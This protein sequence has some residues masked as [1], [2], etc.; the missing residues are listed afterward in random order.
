MKV[1]SFILIILF[2]TLLNAQNRQRPVSV[3]LGKFFNEDGKRMLYGGKK[4]YQHF[5]VSNLSLEEDQFHYGL[6]REAF[7]ALLEPEF[8][9][10]QK[11]DKQWDDDDRFLVAKSG[12]DV[13]AYSIKDL[14]RHEIVNDELNGKPIMATYCILADLGAIYTRTYGDKVFTFALS[15]Y[16]YYDPEVWDG[17]DGFVFWDRETESLWWPLIGKAV[18]GKMKGAKLHIY[19]ET[20]WEDTTWSTV[21]SKYPNAKVLISGQDFERP[22]SWRKYE[23]VSDVKGL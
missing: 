1:T 21:K 19:D 2:G 23:D 20:K 6:G 12:N 18:S 15:G 9:S 16:T 10:I 5:D 22:T 11:A 3:E 8:T 17:L 13:K 4:D 7:P 14:T